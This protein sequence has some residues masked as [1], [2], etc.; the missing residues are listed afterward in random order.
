MARQSS[1]TPNLRQTLNASRRSGGVIQHVREIWGELRKVVWPSREETTR[2]T[3]LVLIVAIVV[4]AAL[5]LID[6]GFEQ[7]FTRAILGG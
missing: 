3:G 1:N 7:L 5:S 4:G 2:L 6:M